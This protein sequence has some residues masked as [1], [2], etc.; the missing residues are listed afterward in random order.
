MRF[1]ITQFAR[2]PAR[3]A[4]PYRKQPTA[5]FCALKRETRP[6]QLQLARPLLE[7]V[8]S[9]CSPRHKTAVGNNCGCKIAQNKPDQQ[10]GRG[11]RYDAEFTLAWSRQCASWKTR[12]SAVL[13]EKPV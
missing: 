2:W 7:N 8:K 6:V 1:E 4:T 13:R 3:W 12:F 10:S 9:S 5:W 11:I